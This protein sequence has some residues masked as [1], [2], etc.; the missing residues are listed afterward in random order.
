MSLSIPDDHHARSLEAL[1]GDGPQSLHAALEWVFPVPTT[2][3]G[4][5]DLVD[6]EIAGESYWQSQAAQPRWVRPVRVAVAGPDEGD[7]FELDLP[8]LC[9][10]RALRTTAG[11]DSIQVGAHRGLFLGRPLQP[12]AQLVPRPGLRTRHSATLT[13]HVLVPDI[14]QDVGLARSPRGLVVQFGRRPPRVLTM[15]VVDQLLAG[16][17]PSEVPGDSDLPTLSRFRALATDGGSWARRFSP[18]TLELIDSDLRLAEASWSSRLRAVIEG[19]EGLNVDGRADV[20]S[21]GLVDEISEASLQFRLY[22]DI[23]RRTVAEGVLRGARR[24]LDVEAELVDA[25]DRKRTRQEGH[26]VELIARFTA[27]L[28]TEAQAKVDHTV[29]A[30]TTGAIVAPDDDRC[31]VAAIESRRIVTRYGP[32]GVGRPGPHR[33]WLRGLHPGR[34]GQL[35][36]LLTPESEDIGFVRSLCLGADAGP[37]A[38][39]TSER[40][41]AFADLSIA[42]GLVPFVNH[43]DPTRA[44]I[45]A[46]MLRQAVPIVGAQ[47]PRIET[48]VADIVAED[49]GVVRAPITGT[50]AEVGKGWL[51]IR[52]DRGHVEIVGLGPGKPS[53]STVVSD[54][55]LMVRNGDR[56]YE[57]DP[58]AHAPDVVV[59]DGR[60]HLAAGRDCL[61]AYTPWRGWNYE[62]AVVVSEAMAAMFSSQH[63]VRFVEPLDLIAT[64][65]PVL[66]AEVGD[67]VALGADLVSV[68]SRHRT[69]RVVR[70]S[71]G[72]VLKRLEITGDLVTVELEVPR[73]LQLGDKLTNRHGA[74][75]VVAA[76]LPVDQMPRLAD[77]RPVEV[78]LNPLGVI[79][80]L[81]ISQL[82]ETHLTL[83]RDR[84]GQE[85]TQV[86]G[87]R[88]PS[89]QELRHALAEAEAPG[90]RLPLFGPDGRSVGDEGGVVV[91]WQ[92]ILKLDHLAAHKLRARNAGRFSPR[93][94]QPA[95][96]GGWV[97]GRLVGGAQRLGEMEMWALQAL[98]ADT[99]VADAMERSDHAV[100][101]LAAVRA[102]LLVAGIQLGADETGNIIVSRHGEPTGLEPIPAE[103]VQAITNPKVYAEALSPQRDPLHDHHHG[104]EPGEPSCACGDTGGPGAVCPHCG[105][106]T[107]RAAGYERSTP[108]FAIDLS[109]PVPHPWFPDDDRATL[110]TVPLLP[111]AY[112][113]FHDNRLDIAY[114]RLVIINE[115]LRGRGADDLGARRQLGAAVQRVLGRLDDPPELETISSRLNGKRGLLRR[116][117]RGRDTDF[118]ARGVMVPDPEADP[119]TIGVPEAVMAVLGLHPG[120]DEWGDIVIVN[121]QPTLLPTNIVALRA[122]PVPG[123]AFRVH[124]FLCARFAGDFD[125]D[126]LTVHRPLSSAAAAEAWARFRPAASYRHP[127][128]GRPVAKV[129]LDVALGLWLTGSDPAGRARLAC[130]LG[131]AADDPV[132]S[133]TGPV[134][135]VEQLALLARCA[136]QASDGR[137][138]VERFTALFDAGVVAATGWSFSAV[139]VERVP[140][141]GPAGDA[142]V[143]SAVPAGSALGQAI[144]AGVAGKAKGIAQLVWRR[145]SLDGF[146]GRPTPEVEECFLTGLDDAGFFHTAAGG[147]RA[148]S[149]KK[150]V[151]A[152]AG[153]LTKALIEAAY[154]LTVEDEDCGSRHRGFGA[155]LSCRLVGPGVCA[156]CVAAAGGGTVGV[157]DRVGLQAGFAI[158]ERCTQ[159]AMKAF[160][161]GTTLAVGGNVTRLAALFGQGPITTGQ[162]GGKPDGATLS[163]LL[164]LDRTPQGRTAM[165]ERLR[166]QADEALETQVGPHHLELLWRRLVSAHDTRRPGELSRRG[167][168][169]LLAKAQVAGTAFVDATSRGRLDLLLA[170]QPDVD[171][172]AAGPETSLRMRVI[173]HLGAVAG[174]RM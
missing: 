63:V 57:G 88:L 15:A 50:V 103:I 12:R 154:D 86:V 137:I 26:P 157:G 23:L 68:V 61:V 123:V 9:D 94:Q 81:N 119:E 46:R 3:L 145:G 147:L 31:T 54:W 162:L 32:G 113:P 16:A 55:R 149:D 152:L 77:G 34:R 143:T 131:L 171:V 78:L 8:W 22:G 40:G 91:G 128:N 108:R 150:L 105:S 29:R 163:G 76:V 20:P 36:P 69:R 104:V 37:E 59:E 38:I 60:P 13:F 6:L 166:H 73:P 127:A 25:A 98:G 168:G 165:F 30:S 42:A 97:A 56:V 174:V 80:R 96:G 64:E 1:L 47:R 164:D 39:A 102:H 136:E 109:V 129:D 159:N 155:V 35:C 51:S 134:T 67:L 66:M 92:H 141:L 18:T 65:T 53:P 93:T 144:A 19:L 124:P 43:D 146:D 28:R 87:R 21:S 10:D 169:T 5:V 115:K 7:L 4:T 74:K 151:T 158:G 27:K 33:L 120:T 156:R 107:A 79:R 52:P 49:H 62:D 85:G 121:R 130:R 84:Q 167:N 11:D 116:S 58:V 72:G 17:R 89:L 95:K 148:L 142:A 75:G 140:G 153:G 24:F 83:L 122:R 45:A 71:A 101:S 99:V 135:P 106:R 48:P 2:S 133:G 44:S 90:G 126:E 160:Q 114:R 112:R 172:D 173:G 70:A 110:R 82:L 132:N 170:D 117:L 111:P 125:G 138:A 161:G 100:R 118:A 14:G 139:E 41:G